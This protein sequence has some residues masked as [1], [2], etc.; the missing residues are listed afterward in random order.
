MQPAPAVTV[1]RPESM[2]AQPGV[3]A[4]REALRVEYPADARRKEQEGSVRVR[5]RVLADGSVGQVEVV[6]SSGVQSLD[7][8]ATRAA[9]AA[10]FTPPKKPDGSPAE[11]WVILPVTFLLEP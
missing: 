5:M 10:K 4:L 2:A 1:V 11:A 7:D 9:A 3:P 6:K 8:A